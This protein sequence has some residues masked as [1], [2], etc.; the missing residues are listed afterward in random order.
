MHRLKINYSPWKHFLRSNTNPPYMSW[1]NNVD[2]YED[3]SFRLK[4]LSVQRYP[5]TQPRRLA[6][7]CVARRSNGHRNPDWL[8]AVNGN[9][10]R[11]DWRLRR[12]MWALP[13]IIWWAA[14]WLRPTWIWRLA[15]R[16]PSGVA[17]RWNW[18][19]S[20]SASPGGAAGRR[21]RWRNER[22]KWGL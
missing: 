2:I 4:S 6:I 7:W 16:L 10:C 20:I 8:D 3:L 18:K 1:M 12:L 19:A 11:W 14:D 13:G 5:M 15:T 9:V 21:N 22:P 17:A